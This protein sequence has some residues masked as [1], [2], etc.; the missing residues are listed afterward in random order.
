MKRIFFSV[1][2]IAILY[3]CS[4]NNDTQT[5]D[6]QNNN[7]YALTVGNSWEY[8]WY[9]I[10]NEGFENPTDVYE[11]VSIVGTED[12][13]G[14]EYFK[15][16]RVVTGNLY[17]FRP[18]VPEDGEHFEYY[19]DSLGFLVNQNGYIK[20][21]NTHQ[22][23]ISETS[24][25]YSTGQGEFTYSGYAE[26]QDEQVDYTTNAGT[27]NCKEVIIEY[28]NENGDAYLAKNHYYYAEGIGLI[29][30]DNV[31]LGSENTADHRKLEFYNVQ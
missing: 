14:I 2:F 18:Y 10:N 19:R 31:F 29:K 1:C 16:S 8:R 22:N 7:F 11:T 12:F 5:Q 30:E 23:Y 3:S 25:L 24:T 9:N 28:I 26:L 17:G 21:T 20:F 6:N 4:S 15:F 27:F 13:N